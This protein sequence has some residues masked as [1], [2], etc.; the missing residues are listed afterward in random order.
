[1]WK[2]TNKY[3]ANKHTKK[4]VSFPVTPGLLLP[5]GWDIAAIGIKLSRRWTADSDRWHLHLA[6]GLWL[7]ASN[8]NND[9]N[10]NNNNNNNF[11]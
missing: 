4:S 5:Y 7:N 3:V 11:I 10:N 2:F 1:M 9:N 8:N 6:V